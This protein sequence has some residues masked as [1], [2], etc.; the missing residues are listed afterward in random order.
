VTIY[1]A[2]FGRYEELKEPTIITPNW[3]YVCYTDQDFKSDVW[4]IRKTDPGEASPLL[5]ARRLKI[6]G[7]GGEMWID[8]SFRI[9]TDLNW[10]WEKH[11]TPPFTVVQHPM[12]N[13]VYQEISK[14]IVNNRARRSDLI[15]QK[16]KY[17]R[18]GLPKDNGLIQSG[19]LMRLDTPEVVKFCSLWWDQLHL[20]VRDQIGFAYA[21][22]KLGIKWPR[23]HIDYRR[24]IY[25]KFK[26]HFDRR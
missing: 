17:Y 26:T 15:R 2:I 16:N 11:F 21:E 25:F 13:C 18:E 10:F 14:C 5:N 8:G 12:R 23:I 9:D 24:N 20:S 1:T 22:W 4:E 19:I 7:T 3:N 6:L